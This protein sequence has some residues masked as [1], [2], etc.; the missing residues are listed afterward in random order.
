M[1]KYNVQAI[2]TDEY[3]IEIDEN[4]WT[5][6]KLKAWSEVFS[7][8]EDTEDLAEHLSSLLLGLGYERFLE[9]FGYV[10]TEN[11]FGEKLSQ[12]HYDNNG[13]LVKVTDFAEGIKVKIITMDDDYD[14]EVDEI[15]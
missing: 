2:R 10:Y 9:G 5:D 3:E 12:Y 15:Q 11:Q 6:E 7:D 14:Y 4:V 8:C 1:K 13:K